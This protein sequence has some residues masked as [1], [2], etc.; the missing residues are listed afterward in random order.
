[1]CWI[2][3][4]EAS[5]DALGAGLA[6]ELRRRRPDV[7]LRGIAGPRMRA[8][9]VEPVV[10]AEDLTTFGLAEAAVRAPRV[11][12]SIARAMRNLARD[13][14][15]LLV[16][17]DSPDMM[18][19]LG[20]SA[21]RIHIPAIHWVSPQI[22][23]W[24][25][26][27]VDRIASSV[28]SLLC[29]L[30][31]E[32]SLYAG[33]VRAVFVGHPAAGIVPDPIPP[34]GHPRLALCPGSRPSEIDR[35]W[36][37]MKEVA[38]RARARWPTAELLVPVAP[39][40]ERGRLAGLDATFVDGIA[41]VAGASVA[42]TASGTATLEL[43]ALGIPQVVVYAVH[44]VTAAVAR[45]IVRAPYAALPNLIAGRALVPEHLQDLDPDRL[46]ADVCAVMGLRDQVPRELI[47]ELNGPEAYRRAADE[48][49]PWLP[50]VATH[51]ELHA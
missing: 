33:K 15:S 39:T 6:V 17:I 41:K 48:I 16:T 8:A 23:A 5:G 3:A 47:D 50:A 28:D 9:G 40:I 22:W 24:R 7:S 42:L 37:V 20:R 51:R 49:T 1:M 46:F 12:W 10:R 44:P 35:L 29:L 18:L 21:R 36:P 14:P 27:R 26:G 30:P 31:F 11:A 38:R 13:P 32:P 2:A 25:P 34:R 45:V 4:A 19:R 43:A